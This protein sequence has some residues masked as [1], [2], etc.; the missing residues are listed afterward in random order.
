MELFSTPL[1]SAL[2]AIVVI[3]LVL[4]GDNAIVI[5][6]AARNLPQHLR[7]KAIAWGTVGAVVVRTAMTVAV[8]GLL[9]IPGLLFAGGAM[10]VWVAYK[11]LTD[12]AAESHELKAASSFWGA[13]RTIVV[14]D[15]LM[16]L[17]NVLAVAGAAHG[18]VLLVVAGLLISIPIVVWGSQV[19]LR[20]VER[21]PVI[22]YV[23]AGVLAWTAVKM[24][25]GEPL[26]A[27]YLHEHGEWALVA[28]AVVIGGVLGDGFL[29]NHAAA[30]KRV[31]AHLVDAAST[32]E[33]SDAGMAK[34]PEGGGAMRKVLIPVDESPNALRAVRHVV[35]RYMGDASLEVHV[36]HVRTP[37]SRYV[38]RF[39]DRRT[40]G[41]YHAAAA[42]RATEPACA[43]LNR[44]GVPHAVHVERGDTAL[45]INRL[46]QRLRIEQ[47]VIGTARQSSLTR[48]LQD[49]V[50]NRLLEIT[51]VPVE[52][53]AGDAVSRLERYGLPASVGAAA[54]ALAYLALD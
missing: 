14:A 38:A 51:Q 41:A 6:L 49:S 25:T 43:L 29:R 31:V 35:N 37:F 48:M 24:M 4:A 18:N 40:R 1:L 54:V 13:M 3:D 10:L 20:F 2:A 19:I 9:K 16:G 30:R 50:T 42:A 33:I 28:Y 44:F 23:G 46:A 34:L 15:A 53:V 17:D 8:V 27:R 11:L 52:V 7:L 22:V 21:Y 45:T 5:A 12:D 32:A 47:I 36:V 26:L 39:L